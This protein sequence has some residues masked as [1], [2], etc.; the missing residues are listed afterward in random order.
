MDANSRIGRDTKWR[1]ST[2][3]TFSLDFRLIVGSNLRTGPPPSNY[4][5]GYLRLRPRRE[6]GCQ[7][8]LVQTH[9]SSLLPA[10]CCLHEAGQS[11]ILVTQRALDLIHKMLI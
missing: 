10:P 5:R 6:I 2:D 7:L 11:L 4:R 1:V 9:S 3:Y 8:Q